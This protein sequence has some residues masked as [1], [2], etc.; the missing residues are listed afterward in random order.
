MDL[1]VV[2]GRDPELFGRF[3]RLRDDMQ[4]AEEE[5]PAGL[6]LEEARV[7]FTGTHS[8]VRADGLAAV[9]GDSWLGIAWLDWWLQENTHTVEV[10]LAVD[11][12]SGGREWAA[13][14]S[15]RWPSERARTAAG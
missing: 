9:D 7:M 15:R 10:E 1:L 5:F 11:P 6:G 14:C 12:A 4:R 13:S 2:D 3:F 8:D